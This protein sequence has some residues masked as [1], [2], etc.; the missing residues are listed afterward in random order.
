[1]NPESITEPVLLSCRIPAN[2]L[3]I[4]YTLIAAIFI[5]AVI[6]CF[7]VIMG[8]GNSLLYAVSIFILIAVML[9]IDVLPRIA[10]LLV[11][12]ASGVMVTGILGKSVC[13]DAAWADIISIK[14]YAAGY[15]IL[16]MVNRPTMMLFFSESATQSFISMLHEASNARVTG[17]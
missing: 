12:T 3:L 8:N 14:R 13:F 7:S 4:L 1:M 5:L 10:G 15:I 16:R 2:K 11:C 9:V 17:F 6:V